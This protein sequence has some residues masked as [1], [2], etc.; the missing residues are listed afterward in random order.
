[1]WSK[2]KSAT[3][4]SFARV[5]A[6]SH[7]AIA[8][9]QYVPMHGDMPLCR[10][11]H[12]NTLLN[13]LFHMGHR[14]RRKE[15]GSDSFRG[16]EVDFESLLFKITNWR[17]SRISFC[18]YQLTKSRTRTYLIPVIDLSSNWWICWWTCATMLWNDKIIKNKCIGLTEWLRTGTFYSKFPCPQRRW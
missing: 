5:Y 2:I 14:S 18:F 13:R 16:C 17:H 11:R 8:I 4:R 12:S 15:T 3:V 7:T 9:L 6:W 1:M 10:R